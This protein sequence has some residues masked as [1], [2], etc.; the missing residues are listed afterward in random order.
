MDKEYSTLLINEFV[1][2]NTEAPL[3]VSS[4][5]IMMMSIGTG[6]E[7]TENQWR[8]LLQSIGLE[9]TKIWTANMFNES[10]IEAKVSERGD[11]IGAETI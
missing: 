1:L 10:I 3:M 8:D 7:R 6:M 2:P 11:I 4:Y 9:I 5:D